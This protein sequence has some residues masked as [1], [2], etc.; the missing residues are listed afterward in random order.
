MFR[1]FGD[2]AFE[3]GAGLDGLLLAQEALAE[4][5]TGVD[6]V[7]LAFER[8][9]IAGF[10]LVEFAAS[11]IDIAELKVVM[12]FIEMIDLRL[13]LF[14]TLALVGAGQFETARGG[15]SRAI[16]PEVIKNGGY[17]PADKNEDRPNPFAAAKGINEHPKL[18]QG[19]QQEPGRMVQRIE[20]EKIRD[21]GGEHG[22]KRLKAEG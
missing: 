6:V 21:Q 16:N 13:E 11:E 17:S 2:H 20:V 18:K 8:G 22:G 1:V 10:G 7:R 19:N 3:E 4:M 15:G 5:G 9:A 14:D 12:G